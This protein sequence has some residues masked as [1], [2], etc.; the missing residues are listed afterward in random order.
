MLA[1][2]DERNNRTA[3]TRLLAAATEEFAR[4]GFANARIRTIAVAARVN[5]AAA[6]YYFGGKKGLY[7]AT[8]KHLADRL[9]PLDA[10][11][12]TGACAS[13]CP[14]H[15]SVVAMLNRFTGNTHAVP[16]AKILAHEALAPSGQL[17]VILD[18]ALSAE[19]SLLTS[20][21]D[22][23]ATNIDSERRKKAARSILGQCVLCLFAGAETTETTFVIDDEACE[24]LATQITQLALGTLKRLGRI[25]GDTK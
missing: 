12:L 9:E 11:E 13:P 24:V 3:S 25:S 21:V 1:E 7:R 17:E 4:R 19:I 6:N 22:A 20:A 14:M 16:L 8:L 23:I 5:P 2:K 18:D 15:R 10:Q